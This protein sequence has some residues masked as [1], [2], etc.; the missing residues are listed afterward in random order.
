[1]KKKLNRLNPH[2]VDIVDL[3]NDSIA[4]LKL[5]EPQEAY[6]LLSE[7][8]DLLQESASLRQPGVMPTRN[9]YG[10]QWKDVGVGIGSTNTCLARNPK[11]QPSAAATGASADAETQ[12]FFLFRKGLSIQ[13]PTKRELRR[14][15]FCPFGL[16]WALNYNLALTCHIL[17]IGKDDSTRNNLF[18]EAL[19]LYDFVL[20]YLEQQKP[21][22]HFTILL[23]GVL[24][25]K[26][27]IYQ[28]L[29]LT[30]DE[31]CCFS[32]L[33]CLLESTQKTNGALGWWRHFHLNILSLEQQGNFAA[34]A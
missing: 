7:A 13:M 26:G 21:T 1:M 22:L 23:M 9:G 28:E 6:R 15:I 5:G 4:Y 32:V 20:S 3:N 17:A 25:N 11:Q 24:N 34:A 2:L 16:L 19:Q 33:K 8:L 18:R 10:F 31:R 14:E 12:G 27:F 30:E 29:G